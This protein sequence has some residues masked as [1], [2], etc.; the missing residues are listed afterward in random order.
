MTAFLLLGG[1]L[2]CGFFLYVLVQF[3]KEL[4]RREAHTHLDGRPRTRHSPALKF[5]SFRRGSNW[6]GLEL[7]GN[8]QKVP[9]VD[10]S[11]HVMVPRDT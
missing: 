4:H 5:R 6:Q 1:G 11:I 8:S 10:T 7:R 3:H 9:L 2:T